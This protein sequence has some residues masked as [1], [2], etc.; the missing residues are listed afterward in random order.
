MPFKRI[1]LIFVLLFIVR[2]IYA[3]KYHG[4]F[5]IGS[6]IAKETFKE[7]TAGILV[8]ILIL[9][10]RASI[11]TYQKFQT[12]IILSLPTFETNMTFLVN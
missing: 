12:V 11:F 7:P 10:H 3:E 1:S 4:R 8:M 2:P 6:F 9:F 5:T